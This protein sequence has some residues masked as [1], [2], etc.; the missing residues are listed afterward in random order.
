MTKEEV[1][2][3]VNRINDPATPKPPGFIICS[4]ISY[5]P[6]MFEHVFNSGQNAELYIMSRQIQ[7]QTY[8]LKIDPKNICRVI[9]E[10]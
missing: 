2:I 1:D 8:S 7:P 5:K 6:I 9:E 3:I 10:R 4:V